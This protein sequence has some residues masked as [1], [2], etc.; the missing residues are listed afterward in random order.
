MISERKGGSQGPDV[1]TLVEESI[2]RTDERYKSLIPVEERAERFGQKP[3]TLLLIGLHGAHKRPI[4][5]A[6]ERKLHNE[7]RAVHVMEGYNTHV[8][9]SIDL[10]FRPH[11]CSEN[12]RRVAEVARLFNETGH[13][14]ICAL[15]AHEAT[16]R[17]MFRKVV[18]QD[19]L[20]EVYLSAPIEYCRKNDGSGLY[21]RADAG[22]VSHVPGVTAP[23]EVPEKPDL[24]LPTHEVSQ[25]KSVDA[26]VK[27]LQDRKFIK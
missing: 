23:F 5:F 3:V 17:E 2:R 1:R 6:L 8:G 20:L 11:D 24:V 14:S 10:E 16:D 13:I 27:L 22:E 9:L 19:R 15:T 7:G 26:L 25:E 4:A 12:M 18:G 21:A